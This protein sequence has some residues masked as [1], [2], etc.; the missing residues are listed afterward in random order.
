MSHRITIILSVPAARKSSYLILS[1]AAVAVAA[2]PGWT[3]TQG[4]EFSSHETAAKFIRALL[5]T[6]LPPK[7]LE[8][9]S[10]ADPG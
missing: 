1:P 6:G 4:Q 2:A 7:M 8:S 3:D 5:A 10:K 9:F